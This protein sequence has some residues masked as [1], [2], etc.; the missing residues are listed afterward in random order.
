MLATLVTLFSLS[1]PALAQDEFAQNKA[2]FIKNLD[3]RITLIQQLKTCAEAA[4]NKEDMQKC[5][6]KMQSG[7]QAMGEQNRE[8]RKEMKTQ[9][10]EKRIQKLEERK[11]QLEEKK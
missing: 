1:Q 5:H 3:A 10:I 4:N 7:Q 2:N 6:A 11:K 8:Q 9:K